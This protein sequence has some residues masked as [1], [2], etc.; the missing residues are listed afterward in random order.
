MKTKIKLN[1]IQFLLVGLEKLKGLKVKI[2]S[3]KY[4][5]LLIIKPERRMR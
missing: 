4:Y 2:S 3:K 5:A 1:K